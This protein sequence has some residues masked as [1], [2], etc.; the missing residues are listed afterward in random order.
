MIFIFRFCS[1]SAVMPT[2]EVHLVTGGC[3]YPGYHLGKK[4]AEDG[5]QVIL[6]DII[7]SEWPLHERMTVV[8]V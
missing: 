1:N 5:H 6:F 3:G 2:S 7:K 8:Q 4:L